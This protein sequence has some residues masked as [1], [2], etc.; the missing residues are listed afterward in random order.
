[1]SP[2]I[3]HLPQNFNLFPA[4]RPSFGLRK[5]FSAS[6]TDENNGAACWKSGETETQFFGSLH[7][8]EKSC[9]LLPAHWMISYGLWDDSVLYGVLFHHRKSIL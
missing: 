3:N 9:P 4:E 8:K 1:M 7:F 5:Q 6:E 2:I